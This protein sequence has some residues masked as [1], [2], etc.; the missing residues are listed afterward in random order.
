MKLS[1]HLP[2]RLLIGVLV[3]L[4][5]GCAPQ[6]PASNGPSPREVELSK[7]VEELRAK[8]AAAEQATAQAKAETARTLALLKKNEPTPAVQADTSE[9]SPST[10]TKIADTSYIVVK[11]TLTPGQLISKPTG[12]EPNRTERRPAEYHITFKGAQS[13]KEYPPLEVQE[14]AYGRFR[15]GVAYSPQDINAAKKPSSTTGGTGK[16]TGGSATLS[17]AELRTIFGN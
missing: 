8:L 17:D 9:S 14:L 7:T 11:K 1:A 13:G 5:S 16:T 6:P 3:A 12:A 4:A 15:E 10:E 2:R